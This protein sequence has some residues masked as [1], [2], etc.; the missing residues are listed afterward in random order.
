MSTTAQ[1][2]LSTGEAAHATGGDAA[3]DTNAAPAA[4]AAPTPEPMVVGGLRFYTRVLSYFT[5]DWFYIVV[6][7]T[8]IGLATVAMLLEP[9]PLAALVD[10]VLSGK[11]ASGASKVLLDWAPRTPAGQIVALAAFA[12]GFRLIRELFQVGR[13]IANIRVGYSGL[14][15]VRCDLFNK[16]QQ[17]SLAYYRSQPQGDAIYRLGTDVYSFQAMFNAIV[18]QVLISAVTILAMAGMML[19]ID[20]RLALVALGVIPLLVWAH[21]HF[22]RV[23]KAKWTD[24]K[25]IDSMLTTVIQ[26]SLAT[27]GLVQAFGQ[28]GREYQRFEKT[29]RS[30][31]HNYVRTFFQ[32]VLYGLVVG[33]ILGLGTAAILGYGGYLVYRDQYV[34]GRGEHGFTLGKLLIFISYMAAFYNPLAVLSSAGAALAQGAIGAAR[35]FE[36]L[37]RVPTVRDAPDATPLPRQARVIEFRAVRFEYLPGTPVIRDLTATIR[38]GQMVAFV[39][40]SGVGKST[41]LSL[42][43]RFYDVTGGAILIDGHDVRTV[44]IADLRRHVALVLQENAILPATVAENI[45]YGR[46]D[47][48][49][50]Q[51]ERAAKQ[52]EADEFI[53]ALPHGYETEISESGSNLSGGQRQRIAIARAL[54]TEAPV[55]ILDEPTSA[56]D[57]NNERQ[58]T[59]TLNSL[60]GS[61]TIVL[62]SHRLSTVVECDQIFVMD[63]GRVV[64]RGTH[65]ELLAMRGA[66]YE[67]ARHQLQIEE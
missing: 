8:M 36:V 38:P 66:Y 67:M 65:A 31:I 60:K 14:M 16:L 7:L 41:I 18:N 4:A 15:R 13:Q 48:T 3:P 51:I 46:P 52:A 45:S 64:E 10:N 26:R 28:E 20:W 53:R 27:M 61:R 35:S 43:P 34:L 11:P 29:V 30:S 23:L 63:A 54:A 25:A 9:I 1:E 39:G 33:G 57:P 58:V 6:I 62:V 37:D 42:L 47:A 50:E 5:A 49:K 12:L 32:E 55:M 22:S 56:L 19:Y 17:L 2:N 59:R 40:P 44:K 24:V 21:T